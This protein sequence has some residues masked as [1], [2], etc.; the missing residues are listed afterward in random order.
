MSEVVGKLKKPQLRGLLHS[1]IKRNLIVAGVLTVAVGVAHRIF[2]V[3][4]RKQTYADYYK[5]ENSRTIINPLLIAIHFRTYDA[6]KEFNRMRNKGLF[7]SC[8]PDN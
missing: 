1:Q 8:E 2:V 7:D 5:L 3:E 4:A 6:E